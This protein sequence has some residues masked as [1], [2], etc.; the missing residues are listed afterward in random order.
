M[1]N[2]RKF[3]TLAD[4]Q[5]AELVKPAVSLIASD[6]SVHFDQK[7]PEV[8]DKIMMAWHSPSEEQSGKDIVLYNGG[9]SQCNNNITAVVVNNEDIVPKVAVMEN[10]SEPDTDYLV[11]YSYSADSV[12]DAFAG[13]LGGGWG[14]GVEAIEFLIPSQITEISYLPNNV[15]KLVVEAATPPTA[16]FNSSSLISGGKL[17]G[18]YV[19]DNAVNDYKTEW[20]LLSEFINSIED[21]QGLL[22]V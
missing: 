5:S 18:I 16:E 17:V 1:N 3:N 22:P 15:G 2:L 7:T 21:Y 19:P 8:N 4:Y 9:S 10:A 12:C 14:S 20:A 6:D 13:D 11:K